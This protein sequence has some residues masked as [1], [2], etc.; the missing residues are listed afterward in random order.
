MGNLGLTSWSIACSGWLGGSFDRLVVRL[1]AES[2]TYVC[3]IY[4]YK[5]IYQ[6]H[7]LRISCSTAM[8]W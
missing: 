1:S 6:T 2:I 3:I 8:L 4:T 7:L 5:T